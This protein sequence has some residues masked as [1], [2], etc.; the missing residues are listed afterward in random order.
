MKAS[1]LIKKLGTDLQSLLAYN[2]RRGNPNSLNGQ[3]IARTIATNPRK[4]YMKNKGITVVKYQGKSYI[5][6]GGTTY[7]VLAKL[8][9]QG[10]NLKKVE[11]NVSMDNVK[12][13]DEI[14]EIALAKN[15]GAAVKHTDIQNFRNSFKDIKEVLKGSV[16][17]NLVQFKNGC[18]GVKDKHADVRGLPILTLLKIYDAVQAS[19]PTEAKNS[20]S[21]AQSVL[22]SKLKFNKYRNIIPHTE[23]AI[24]LF[25]EVNKELK[26]AKLTGLPFAL[27]CMQLLN[28]KGNPIIYWQQ[29]GTDIVARLKRDY[30]SFKK[31]NTGIS[32]SEYGRIGRAWQVV[33]KAI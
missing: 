8:H 13:L 6:D 32:A 19:T 12:S 9:K 3:E 4:F 33:N 16:Y 24:S 21:F 25:V 26:R 14:E 29:Y 7:Q 10:V 1:E 20:Y 2:P 5:V 17:E 18:L 22:L 11:V 28:R 15:S 27:A 31:K 23:T 30:I